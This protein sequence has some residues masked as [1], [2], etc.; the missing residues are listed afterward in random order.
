MHGVG[1]P[2]DANIDE[3]DCHVSIHNARDDNLHSLVGN[4]EPMG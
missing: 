2:E 3:F 4:P 1:S